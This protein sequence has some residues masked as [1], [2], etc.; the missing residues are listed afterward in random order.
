MIC[1]PARIRPLRRQQLQH[2]QQKIRDPLRLLDAE[3]VLLAQHVGQRPVPQAV[4]VAQLALAVED[5]LRPFSRDAQGFG[6]GAE[7]L[8][9][10]RDVVV[11]FAVFGA[12]LWVEEVVAC[13]EFEDLRASLARR[14]SFTRGEGITIAAILQTSVLAPHLAPK[15]TSGDRYCRVW[16]SFVK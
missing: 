3:M 1:H 13:D 10:L 8:D 16:I 12:G 9:D 2:R 5:L 15:M 4:D 7:Q 11:V 14:H 6:E